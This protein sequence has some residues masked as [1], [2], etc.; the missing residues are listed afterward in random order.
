[1][2]RLEVIKSWDLKQMAHFLY[3]ISTMCKRNDELDCAACT[4]MGDDFCCM[5]SCINWLNSKVED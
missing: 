5:E 1:M 2:T 3:S 4:H